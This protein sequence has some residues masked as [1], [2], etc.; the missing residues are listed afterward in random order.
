MQEKIFDLNNKNLS[1][2]LVLQYILLTNLY[3][4]LDGD[5]VPNFSILICAFIS[6]F[7]FKNIFF[8]LIINVINSLINVWNK[9]IFNKYIYFIN[10]KKYI[11]NLL[12]IIIFYLVK[13]QSIRNNF[14]YNFLL[15]ESLLW[16]YNYNNNN[17]C[18]FEIINNIDITTYI[19]NMIYKFYNLCIIYKNYNN[20]ILLKK[21]INQSIY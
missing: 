2:I 20:S 16:L 4:Y 9:Y 12:F 15:N 10:L 13:L 17:P 5:R 21:R 11:K 14:I 8:N 6:Y 18:Y 3:N 1:I 7:F 19:E